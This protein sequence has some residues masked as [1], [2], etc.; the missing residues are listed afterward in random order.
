LKAKFTLIA[1]VISMLSSGAQAQETAT[2]IDRTV[3]P[4]EPSK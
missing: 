4:P 2:A 3:L 1:V